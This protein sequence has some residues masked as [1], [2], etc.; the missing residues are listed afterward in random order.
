MNVA[1]LP[2][3]TRACGSLGLKRQF[4][5]HRS[6]RAAPKVLLQGALG[7]VWSTGVRARWSPHFGSLGGCRRPVVRVYEGS[8]GSFRDAGGVLGAARSPQLLTGLLGLQE[9]SCFL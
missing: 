9:P 2:R 5:F 7:R 1:A 8:H 6:E 4:K 3:V